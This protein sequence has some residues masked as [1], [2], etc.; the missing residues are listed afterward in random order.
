MAG[1]LIF[2]DFT[3]LELEHYDPDPDFVDRLNSNEVIALKD[4]KG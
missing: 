2:K 3:S 1:L 4:K